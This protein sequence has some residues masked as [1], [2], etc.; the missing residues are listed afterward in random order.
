MDLFNS[1]QKFWCKLYVSQQSCQIKV[2]MND[3]TTATVYGLF[4]GCEVGAIITQ[5]MN[6]NCMAFE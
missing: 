3:T 2:N 4:Y 1:C 6:K 5:V